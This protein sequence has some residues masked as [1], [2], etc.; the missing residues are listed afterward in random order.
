MSGWWTFT[1]PRGP[2]ADDDP[3][4]DALEDHD[5]VAAVRTRY[6]HIWALAKDPGGSGFDMEDVL[7]D[8]A[9]YWNVP[10]VAWGH[11]N[12]TGDYGDVKIYGRTVDSG[13]TVTDR[14]CE[15]VGGWRGR[16][17]EAWALYHHDIDAR[18]DWWYYFD[19]A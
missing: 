1:V 5:L 6:D 3:L 8:T 15:N 7:S 18:I 19:G 9:E 10:R 11:A 12:D 2:H 14:F 13:P 16:K 4:V 17:A